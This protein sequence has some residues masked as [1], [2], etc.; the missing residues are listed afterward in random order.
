MI[1]LAGVGPMEFQKH[2]PLPPLLPPCLFT[3]DRSAASWTSRLPVCSKA[4]PCN[5]R[6][7]SLGPV[8]MRNGSLV[9]RGDARLYTFGSASA[10]AKLTRRLEVL[11]HPGVEPADAANMS[12]PL[13]IVGGPD[14]GRFGNDNLYHFI[15]E[16]LHPIWLA[17]NST[18]A[19]LNWTIIPV[20]PASFHTKRFEYLL[21]LLPG[22]EELLHFDGVRRRLRRPGRRSEDTETASHSAPLSPLPSTATLPSTFACFDEVI[23]DAPRASPISPNY[24][25]SLARASGVCAANPPDGI[26]RLLLVQRLGSRRI[27][28][29]Q[30]LLSALRRLDGSA[31]D[32]ELGR[33]LPHLKGGPRLLLPRGYS[34]LRVAVASWEKLS[35]AQQLATACASHVLVAAHGSGNHWSLFLNRARPEGAALLEL[36]LADWGNCQYARNF[37]RRGL[38]AE[39]QSHPRAHPE[40]RDFW[41]GVKPDDLVVNVENVTRG[42]VRLIERLVARA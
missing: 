11:G 33:R 41:G 16:A 23:T 10:D 36:A 7:C 24:Y 8:C 31:Q 28:N 25:L 21:S 37:M 20:R 2:P 35:L 12:T 30:S 19:A 22:A 1:S 29:F 13:A 32:R 27:L 4:H 15:D 17:L 38:I 6:A 26:F 42:V 18:P 5:R 40:R 9:R 3:R 34:S 39:C 14:G